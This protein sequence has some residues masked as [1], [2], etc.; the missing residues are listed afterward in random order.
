MPEIVN[1]P[2]CQRQLK[3]PETLLNQ[4]VKCPSCGTLFE[5]SP[6]ATAM[7][8]SPPSS[9]TAPSPP[10][11]TLAPVQ[12]TITPV[13]PSAAGSSAERPGKVQAIAV[14]TLVGGILA[15]VNFL[16][17]ALATSFACCL[18]PGLYYGLVLGIL[19]IVKGAALISVNAAQE[20]PPKTI[21]IMQIVNVI[22]FDIPNCVMGILTLVFLGDPEVTGFFKPPVKG[23]P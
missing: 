1:C 7:A 16:L 12:A 13:A 19:A 18:W 14:M 20:T 9:P 6:S 15:V 5:A 22:N 8:A 23:A 11:P 21:A 2:S 10:A 3:I 17:V 4:R